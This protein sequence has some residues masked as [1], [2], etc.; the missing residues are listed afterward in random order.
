MEN[1]ILLRGL[2]VLYTP[3]YRQCHELGSLINQHLN[4]LSLDNVR[5]HLLIDIAIG[6]TIS[7]LPVAQQYAE[8]ADSLFRNIGYKNEV[9]QVYG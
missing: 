2:V 8:K 5:I 1:S 7:H 9:Y 6:L 3:N 4:H